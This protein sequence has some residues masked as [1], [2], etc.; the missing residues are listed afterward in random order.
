LAAARRSQLERRYV[1]VGGHFSTINNRTGAILEYL[2]AERC[3]KS[4]FWLR[5][6]RVVR[7]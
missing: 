7:E 6:E 2:L 3:R 5:G 4:S 1:P